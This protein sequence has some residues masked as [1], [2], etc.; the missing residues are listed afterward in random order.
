MGIPI[1]Y[2][3][4]HNKSELDSKGEIIPNKGG[5]FTAAIFKMLSCK[6]E[7]RKTDKDLEEST[8]ELLKHKVED[9]HY[10]L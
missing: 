9:Q 3:F 6:A 4:V 7:T 1:Y 2:L 8:N 10:D 5:N